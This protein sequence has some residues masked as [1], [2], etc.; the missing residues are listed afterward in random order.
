MKPTLSGGGAWVCH[1]FAHSI[2]AGSEHIGTL[3]PRKQ[4]NS[5]VPF[6]SVRVSPLPSIRTIVASPT[7]SSGAAVV[8]SFMYSASLTGVVGCALATFARKSSEPAN[9]R[10]VFRISPSHA[11]DYTL[12]PF[13][14]VNNGPEGAG[15]Q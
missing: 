4:V 12:T 2:A 1:A 3:F 6:F 10:E 15:A 11:G 13:W 5:L 9:P 7:I 8:T 14:S